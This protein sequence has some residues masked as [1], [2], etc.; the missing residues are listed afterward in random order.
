MGK[1]TSPPP[2]HLF[3]GIG[4]ELEYMIVDRETLATR[5]IADEV[6][7]EV[8]GSWQTEFEQED[9]CWS[10]ELAMH[11]IELKTRGPVMELGRTISLFQRDISRINEILAS[12]GARLM[13][14]GA[15]P[16][17]DP[18]R[19]TKLWP[20]AHNIIYKSYDRIFNCQGHGWANLQSAHL[21]LP[22]ASD[23]EFGRLHAAIRVLLPIIPALA[24]STPI[25]DL[26][27]Q[28]ALDYRLEVYKA[29]SRLIPSITGRVIP[30]PVFTME[31]YQHLILAPMYR[32]IAPHDSE[33]VLQHE[34]L[35]SRGAIAR[36]SRSAIEIR[37]LDVQECPLADLAVAT[38]IFHALK[39]LVAEKW[40]SYEEQR[41]WKVEPL[42]EIFDGTV[43]N[44][45]E[46]VIA[47]SAYPGLFAMANQEEM[48]A[49]KLWRHIFTELKGEALL[50]PILSQGIE[51]LLE[52]GSLAGRIV[53]SLEP[54]LSKKTVTKVYRELCC[55]L[56]ENRIYQL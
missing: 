20:H 43:K 34:W 30:E 5:P 4:I 33:N 14:T 52:Q 1:M 35:N 17:M 32:D 54:E 28:G 25:I 48:T 6:L 24:A 50:E 45:E 15:H 29:N 44:A 3:E 27:I 10:N 2:L 13:P 19:E 11:V 56:A 38:L 8:T 40:C 49:G 36:F 39:A 42:V 41:Q 55:C 22:F 31:E 51:T 47:S 37:I 18:F 9:I 23:E 7:R 16:W 26:K 46:A 21:N 53:R 12:F